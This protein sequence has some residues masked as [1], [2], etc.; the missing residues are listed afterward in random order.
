MLTANDGAEAVAIF[1]QYKDDIRA[2]IVDVNM[3][4]MNGPQTIKALLRLNPKLKLITIS[5]QAG[6]ENLV[7]REG[8]VKFLQKPYTAEKLLTALE[9]L[10]DQE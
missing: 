7:D 5:G 1:S 4:I 2:A 10:F 6:S 9:E 3:P 8:T